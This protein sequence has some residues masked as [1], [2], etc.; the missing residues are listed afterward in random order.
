MATTDVANYKRTLLRFLHEIA[1]EQGIDLT[2][3][4]HGWIIRLQKADQVR[5]IYGY[6]FDLNSATA[7]LIADDKSAVSDLLAFNKIPHVEHKMF[8]QPRQAHYVSTSGN[9]ADMQAYAAQHKYQVVIKPNSGTSSGHG[10][11]RATNQLELEQAVQE[12]FTTH[13][14]ICL[15]PFYDIQQEYRVVV[16]NGHCELIYSKKRPVIIGDGLKTVA[17]L[18]AQAVHQ[19]HLTE[20]M[21]AQA[22]ITFDATLEQVLAP[23]QPLTLDWRHNLGQGAS[24]TFVTDEATLARLKPLALQTADALQITFASID[25]ITVADELMVLEANAGI[26]MEGFTRLAQDGPEIAKRIYSKAIA[27]MFS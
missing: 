2:V 7:Q 8:L 20:R 21:A 23:D 14:N 10:V 4:S 12:L 25:L 26:M 15:A 22:L 11:L 1:D 27:A 6:S 13:R 17:A 18:I 9:W 24:P 5:F 19:G 16:L 3:F